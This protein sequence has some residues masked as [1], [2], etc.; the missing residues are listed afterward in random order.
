MPTQ[1]LIHLRRKK[2]HDNAEIRL[3]E[4]KILHRKIL[5]FSAL[6]PDRRSPNSVAQA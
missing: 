5:T 1:D 6:Q 4:G 3:M 2:L